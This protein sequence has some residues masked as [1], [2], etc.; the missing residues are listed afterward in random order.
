MLKEERGVPIH[1]RRAM[2]FS[3]NWKNSRFCGSP[4]TL[5]GVE[6]LILETED[7]NEE[8]KK[9][10]AKLTPA[11]EVQSFPPPSF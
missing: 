10:K 7:L 8:G 5:K 11:I 9:M 1:R 3:I 6:A 2:I 4:F